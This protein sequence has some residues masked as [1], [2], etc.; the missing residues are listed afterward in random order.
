MRRE[1][2]EICRLRQGKDILESNLMQ[3]TIQGPEYMPTAI[4]Y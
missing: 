1:H 4:H 2:A 3:N